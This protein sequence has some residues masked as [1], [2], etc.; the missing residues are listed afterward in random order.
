MVHARQPNTNFGFG[1]TYFLMACM[2]RSL[3]CILSSSCQPPDLNLL[4]GVLEEKFTSH[5]FVDIDESG[6]EALE[7]TTYSSIHVSRLRALP[8]HGLVFLALS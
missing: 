7:A 4:V 3:G 5:I 2:H 1:F 6:A 8:I